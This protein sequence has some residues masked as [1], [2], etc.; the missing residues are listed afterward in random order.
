M[1]AILFDD[2]RSKLC[3]RIKREI[4]NRLGGNYVSEFI[5]EFLFAID[6][7]VSMGPNFNLAGVKTIK[8]FNT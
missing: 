7:G 1:V 6:G 8:F 2:I 4:L 5:L 3:A